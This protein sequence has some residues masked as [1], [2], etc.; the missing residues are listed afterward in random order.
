MAMALTSGQARSLFFEGGQKHPGTMQYISNGMD[1]LKE[2]VSNSSQAVSST[3]FK[4]ATS[5]YDSFHGF[6]AQQALRNIVK[7]SEH[8]HTPNVITRLESLESLQQAPQLMQRFIMAQPQIRQAY[9][10]QKIDGYQDTYYDSTPGVIGDG[11]YEYDKVMDGW[12]NLDKV[13]EVDEN[14]EGDFLLYKTYMHLDPMEDGVAL[15]HQDKLDI[16][17]TWDEVLYHLNQGK[18]DPT[19]PFGGLR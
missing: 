16:K 13:D 8:F 4:M 15:S 1:R 3:F 2:L 14:K 17:I 5:A 10:D 9:Y 6:A 7:Q 19:S 12:I 18:H 11:H